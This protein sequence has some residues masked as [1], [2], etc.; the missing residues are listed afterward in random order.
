MDSDDVDNALPALL[1][2]DH[3]SP[4]TRRAI[5]PRIVPDSGWPDPAIFTDQQRE[6]LTAVTLR[7]IPEIP[8][9]P[10]PNLAKTFEYRIASPQGKGWRYATLPLDADTHCRLLDL[11]ESESRT[12]NSLPF[13]ALSESDQDELL[14]DLHAGTSTAPLHTARAFEEMLAALAECYAADPAV[15]VSAG[16]VGFADLP[17]WERIGLDERDDREIDA[18]PSAFHG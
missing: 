8:G 1:A 16:Y 9:L 17:A 2:S 7:L 4:A 11:I 6:T 12:A 5:E 13:Q 3:V 10:R 18:T 14:H 15:L